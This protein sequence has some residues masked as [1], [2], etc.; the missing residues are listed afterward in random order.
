M[1]GCVAPAG[2]TVTALGATTVL[3]TVT[4]KITAATPELGTFGVPDTCTVMVCPAQSCAFDEPRPMRVSRMRLGTI[5]SYRPAAGEETVG[6]A[7]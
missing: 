3:V 1:P 4:F 7:T 2:Q 6:A 5:P